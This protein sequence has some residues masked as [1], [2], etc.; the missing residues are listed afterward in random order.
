MRAL[1]VLQTEA[2]QL[3]AQIID[4]DEQHVATVGFHGGT[5]RAAGE[6]R[7]GPECY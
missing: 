6:H 4:R 5:N 7:N 1:D 3:R 2:A